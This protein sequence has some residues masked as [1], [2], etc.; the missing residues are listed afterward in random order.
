MPFAY[1]DDATLLEV[2][3][4]ALQLG[5]ASESQLAALNSGIPGAFIASA[6]QGGVPGPADHPHEQDEHHPGA[7][8]GERCR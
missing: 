5:F 2:Q 1:L 4:A 6:M 8:V 7:G 3:Q